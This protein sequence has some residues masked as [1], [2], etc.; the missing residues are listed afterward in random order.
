MLEQARFGR[1]PDPVGGCG[2]ARCAPR[3]AVNHPATRPHKVEAGID[4][5]QLGKAVGAPADDPDRV[6]PHGKAE[7]GSPDRDGTNHIS[8]REVDTRHALI[9]GVRNPE[10]AVAECERRRRGAHRYLPGQA[11]RGGIDDR[12]C[13][14]R[15]NR[16]RRVITPD[17]EH[18]GSR[19]DHRRCADDGC[20]EI[21]VA[22]PV[23]GA[24]EIDRPRVEAGLC[25]CAG[26]S[27][28][29]S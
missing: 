12:Y 14:T 1:H 7:W 3:I 21:R 10:T 23:P 16:H 25:R 5:D 29:G 27:I 24:S 17:H 8:T 9:D 15:D 26:W 13:V 18:D 2:D 4:L 28:A 6:P 11:T 20:Q 22:G 19:Q